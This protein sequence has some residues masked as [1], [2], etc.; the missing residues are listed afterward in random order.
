LKFEEVKRREKKRREE[1][2]ERLLIY[3]RSLKKKRGLNGNVAEWI[4]NFNDA[5]QRKTAK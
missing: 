5:S 3:L 2:S 4:N 1:K